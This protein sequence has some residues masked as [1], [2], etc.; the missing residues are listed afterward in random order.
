MDDAIRAQTSGQKSL[1]DALRHLVAWAAQN[2]RAFRTD[3]LP[4]IFRQATGVDTTSIL[5][6]WM[7]PP[8]PA[9][10]NSSPL[11]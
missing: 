5:N 4:E 11:H 1:R 6:S 9:A 7:Q 2:H 10:T 8:R 3:E